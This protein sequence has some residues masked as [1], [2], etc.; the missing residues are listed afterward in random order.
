[1]NFFAAPAPGPAP[2]AQGE[3]AVPRRG[4]LA[5]AS[6][7]RCFFCKLSTWRD[8]RAA[9]RPR[10]ECAV[11]SIFAQQKSQGELAV[12]PREGGLGRG[13]GRIHFARS[14]IKFQGS[15]KSVSFCGKNDCAPHFFFSC[16]QE[17]KKRAAPGAKKKRTFD[18]D[19]GRTVLLSRAAERKATAQ[20]VWYKTDTAQPLRPLPLARGGG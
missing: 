9:A 12:R 17:K 13:G 16:A 20:Q 15:R 2:G 5:K 18:A 4:E 6:P 3:N 7:L 10:R 11:T 14:K 19:S 8:R 1:M